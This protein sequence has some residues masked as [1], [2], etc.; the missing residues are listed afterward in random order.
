MVEISANQS[1]SSDSFMQM[2]FSLWVS[3]ENNEQWA[4]K[5]ILGVLKEDGGKMKESEK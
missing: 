2:L 4:F 1:K 3:R 5:I